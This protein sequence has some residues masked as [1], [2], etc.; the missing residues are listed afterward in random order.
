MKPKAK[1]SV[2]TAMILFLC[3]LQKYCLNNVAYFY[4]VGHIIFGTNKCGISVTPTSQ[5]CMST[6]LLLLIV[7]S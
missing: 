5:M 6:K 3:V 2:S 4:K 7:G 1:E